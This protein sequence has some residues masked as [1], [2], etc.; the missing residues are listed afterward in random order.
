MP[1]KT[2]RKRGGI[3][4]SLRYRIFISMFAILLLSSVIILITSVIQYKEEAKDYNYKRLERKEKALRESINLILRRTIFPVTTENIPLIFKNEVHQLANVHNLNFELYDLEGRLLIGSVGGF[5]K[6]T[7]V[8]IIPPGVLTELSKRP[9]KK[10]KIEEKNIKGDFISAY[11]YIT[12]SKYKPIAILHIPYRAR[13]EFYE[14]EIREFLSRMAK[15]Y[16]FLLIVAVVISFI[17]S[18]NLIKSLSVIS[19]KLKE[20]D[21]EKGTQK[22]EVK[23]IPEELT[24]LIDAYNQMVEK[25]EKSTRRLIK[26]EKEAAWGEMARQVAHEIK[27]PLTPMRLS[28]EHFM[29]TFK[30][31]EPG[32]EEKIRQFGEMLLEQVDVLNHIASSFSDYTKIS[33]LN[34]EYDNIVE[35]VRNTALLF[36]QHVRFESEEEEIYT[37]YDKNRIKQALVNLIRNAVQAAADDRELH[38][39][40]RVYRQENNVLIEVEDTGTGIPD[41][42]LERIFEPKFTTKSSG[43]GLGLAIVKRIIESHEGDIKV[44]TYQDKGTKFILILPVK[45]PRNEIS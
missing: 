7:V 20:T 15:V 31:G 45:H 12:D 28:I 2:K 36:P 8:N 25:L 29:Q 9:D 11:S 6:D 1:E 27:N 21:I 41:E 35:T 17:I 22:L 18:K 42:I 37:L 40:L 30:P 33:D 4:D 34:P 14:Y 24:P 5:G 19:N 16:V 43:A 26:M 38:V 10:L 23:K 13:S 32:N 44:E 3:T 39:T